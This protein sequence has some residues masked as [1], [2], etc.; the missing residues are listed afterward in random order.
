MGA[1]GGYFPGIGDRGA[2]MGMRIKGDPQPARHVAGCG[3]W[4]AGRRGG[5]TRIGRFDDR[6]QP[7]D[8]GRRETDALLLDGGGVEF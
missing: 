4:A 8:Q 1:V 6:F 2:P 7:A 5:G 3:G